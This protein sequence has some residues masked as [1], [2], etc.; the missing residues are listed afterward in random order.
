MT[1]IHSLWAYLVLILLIV[2]TIKAVISFKKEYKNIDL[3]LAL[4]T[5]IVSHIQLVLGLGVYFSSHAYKSLKA[6]GVSDNS[7][8]RILQLDHPI[9]M[10]I[11]I[12]LIT[13][14]YSKH[15]KQTESKS[16]FKTIAVFYGIALILTLKM[17]PW[18][19]WL[20]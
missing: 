9:T 12:I 17:I 6:S 1:M 13:I 16:K 8:L 19:Q 10:I 5:L 4:F 14:G 3:R 7:E 20:Q 2:V 11:A 18:K 15:K